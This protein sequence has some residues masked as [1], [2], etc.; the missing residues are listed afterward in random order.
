MPQDHLPGVRQGE[1][2]AAGRTGH[3]ARVSARLSARS[4]LGLGSYWTRRTGERSPLGGRM[5]HPTTP[6]ASAVH[7]TRGRRVRQLDS[8]RSGAQPH[9]PRGAFVDRTGRTRCTTYALRVAHLARKPAPGQRACH[10]FHQVGAWCAWG[11]PY[12]LWLRAVGGVP[13]RALCWPDNLPVKPEPRGCG[14]RRNCPLAWAHVRRGPPAA[15]GGRIE[16]IFRW[17]RDAAGGEPNGSD[18]GLRRARCAAARIPLGYRT[19][20][21]SVHSSR[22]RH[23]VAMAAWR[24]MGRTSQRTS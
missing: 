23:L 10:G 15:P 7:A 2:P 19:G 16:R 4:R 1:W 5:P 12:R 17:P 11:E 24:M 3:A 13:S 8:G 22:Q 20:R 14:S 18:T 21:A 9:G 6:R